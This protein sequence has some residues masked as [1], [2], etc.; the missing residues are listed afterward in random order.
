MLLLFILF[1]WTAHAD[2]FTV[3]SNA[4]SGP[5]TLREAITA[6]NANGIA[7]ADFIHFNI[8]DVSIAGRTIS[9]LSSFPDL[10]SNLTIDGTT[11]PGN[12][13]GVSSAKIRLESAGALLLTYILRIIDKANLD[14]YGIHFNNAAFA[15]QLHNSSNLKIG[16]A[17]KGN[18]FT[19]LGVGVYYTQLPWVGKG[20]IDGL[21][22]KGNIVNLSEDG[23]S[24]MPY[25]FT[26]GISLENVRDLEI[27]GE[28]PGEG[29]Y[30]SGI[31]QDMVGIGTDTSVNINLGHT[32]IINNK[33]GCNYA[34]T[35]PLSC[36]VIRLKNNSSYFT[37]TTNITVTGNSYNAQPYAFS[38]NMQ[39]FLIIDGKKGFID[40]KKIAWESFLLPHLPHKPAS[41]VWG[42]QLLTATMVS[43]VEIT[44]KT[45]IISQDFSIMVLPCTIIKTF[46]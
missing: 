26:I 36:G 39:S 22:Y 44:S 1:A 45:Q 46:G 3:T 41:W 12:N 43:S 34:E 11:Q 32:K 19:K 35:Q 40:I 16:A 31:N 37:E 7:T 14:I 6:A 10:T 24:I 28:L 15:I 25:S 27:G 17:G 5:G 18:Y 8:P 33:M 9:L 29:N 42:S 21:S 23:N 4:D 30:M 13:I 2:T 20:L 38:N